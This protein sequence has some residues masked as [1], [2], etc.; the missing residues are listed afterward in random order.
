MKELLQKTLG[1]E[2]IH[3]QKLSG[4]TKHIPKKLRP[5]FNLENLGSV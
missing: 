4:K 5:G 2:F 3:Y 1:N